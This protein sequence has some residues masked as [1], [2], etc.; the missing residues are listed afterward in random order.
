MSPT[1][2]QLMWIYKKLSSAYGPRNWWPADSDFEVIVGAVLTQQAPWVNVENAIVNLKDNG[3]LDVQRLANA[4]V[5]RVERLIK[6]AGFYKTKSRRIIGMARNYESVKSAYSMPIDEARE[7]LLS[8]DGVGPE[9]CDSILL[10]AGNVPTFVIDAYTRR[11]VGR[12]GLIDGTASTYD[13]LKAMFESKLP[14]NERLFNEY[15]ALIVELGKNHC[16]VKPECSNCPLSER[17]K[18]RIRAKFNKKKDK[19]RER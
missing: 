7:H 14:R 10:Y 17:C 12:Y 5:T 13:S 16:R 18:K 19:L 11:V 4:E 15:H 9:T 1:K 8:M 2:K 3:L 6:P